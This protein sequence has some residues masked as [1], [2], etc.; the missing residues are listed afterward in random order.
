MLVCV[1]ITTHQAR[2]PASLCDAAEPE[3]I[4]SS[5]HGVD[6]GAYLL[7]RIDPKSAGR[8]HS[9]RQARKQDFRARAVLMLLCIFMG[10]GGAVARADA[11]IPRPNRISREKSSGI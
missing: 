3:G 11:A 2:Q 5:Q 6:K 4:R 10:S 1:E 8:I 9:I 7:R